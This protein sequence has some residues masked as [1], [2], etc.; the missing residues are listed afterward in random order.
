MPLSARLE[1]TAQR[2]RHILDKAWELVET[3]GFLSLKISDLA[4]SAEVSVGTLYVHFESKEDLI[5]AMAMD[6]WQELAGLLARALDMEL[7]AVDRL[8]AFS[9]LDYQFNRKYPMKFE[10][11]QLAGVP[12]IWQR[13]SL[14]RH[15]QLPESCE[16]FEA[17]LTPVIREAIENRELRPEGN[18]EDQIKA[19]GHGLWAANMGNTY[20][21]Y[22]FTSESMRAAHM[23]RLEQNVQRHVLALFQGC[24]WSV[25]DPQAEYL[26]VA[27]ACRQ[28]IP[29]FFE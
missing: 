2:E 23:E 29:Y 24:G 7:K 6:A 11:M 14:R 16:A 10:A 17:H 26:R 18:L 27:D 8:L 15:Q 13:A 3:E 4:K 22:V 20:I 9:I 12:S 21:T 19:F 28:L 1:K 5:T 25:I